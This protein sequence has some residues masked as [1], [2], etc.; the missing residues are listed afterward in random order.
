MKCNHCGKKAIEKCPDPYMEELY[1]EDGPYEDE[2]WCE[3]CLEERRM[4]I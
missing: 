2:W 4:D 1:P 3:E